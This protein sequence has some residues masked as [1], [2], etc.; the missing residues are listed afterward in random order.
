MGDAESLAREEEITLAKRIE[1]AHQAVLTGLCRIPMLVEH[2]ARWAQE[3]AEGRVR[4]ADLVDLSM[5]MGLWG[6]PIGERGQNGRAQPDLPYHADSPTLTPEA[7]EAPGRPSEEDD[8]ETLASREA[9][10]LLTII[11]R[12]EHLAALGHEIALLSQKRLLALARGRD[13]AKGAR[14]RLQGLMSRFASETA[15][16]QL[17]PDR[18]SD[19]IEE[20]DRERRMLWQTE[21]ELLQLGEGRDHAERVTALRGELAALA[22]RVALPIGDFRCAAGEISKAQWELNTARDQMVRAHLRLVV[23]VAKRYRRNSSLD[24]LDLIQEGNL[25][26]MRAI[27]KFDYRRGVKVSS[28]AVWWIR[29]SIARAIADQGRT[30]RIPV[31]MAETASK[32]V[33]ERRKLRQK[34]GREPGPDEI[35]ARAGIPIARVEQVMSMVQQPAS[36]DAPIGDDGDATLGDSIEAT[37][38]IDPQAAAEASALQRVLAEALAELT[39]REQRILRMRF[40]IGGTADHTLAEVG[41]E[42]GV[43]RERIRQIEAKALE[44]LRHPRHARKLASFVDD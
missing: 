42:F 34:Q 5:P 8:A 31:H 6:E 15:S 17:R 12:L 41:K 18:V 38:A 16:L 28:Y 27:E 26:L 2:I 40:G 14:T 22:K 13:L 9:G 10:Q 11:P 3:V 29:Q 32:V 24:L 20:L 33:R 43:T 4:L 37:D 23:W 30:I 25:G 36:L 19:L 1:A 39:P 7:L 35:A 44:K 21:Q